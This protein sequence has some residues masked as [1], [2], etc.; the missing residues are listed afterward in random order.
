[1][2]CTD[3]LKRL[4]SFAMLHLLGI[5]DLRDQLSQC[6]RP[7]NRSGGAAILAAHLDRV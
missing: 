3:T 2:N 4:V 5:K 6:P 1:M 7:A